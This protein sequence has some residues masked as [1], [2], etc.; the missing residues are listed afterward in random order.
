MAEVGASVA[1]GATTYA[2]AHGDREVSYLVH[3]TRNTA[4]LKI[5]AQELAA[6]REDIQKLID[7]SLNNNEVIKKSVTN[8][9]EKVDT[10][11]EDAS[12]LS[13]E[14]TKINRWYKG[15]LYSRFKLGRKAVKKIVVIQELL[16]E[17]SGFVSVGDSKPFQSFEIVSAGNFEA[18]ASREDATKK[19]VDA[20]QNNDVNMIGVFGMPGVGKTVLMKAITKQA[21]DE[22]IFDE[23]VIVSVSQKPDIRAIQKDIAEQLGLDLGESSIPVAA[24]KLSERLSQGKK[25]LVAF[26]DIWKELDMTILGIPYQS[27]IHSCKV[28]FTTRSEDV[29][30]RMEVHKKIEVRVLSEE[31]SWKLFRQKA[32]DVV[33]SSSHQE[34]ARDVFNECKGLPLAIVTL[35]LAL[36]NKDKTLWLD[37]STRLKKSMYKGMGPA[38]AIVKL[39]YDFL[40]D[41]KAAQMCFLFCSLFPEDFFINTDVLLSYML[42]EELMEKGDSMEEARN[43]LHAMIDKLTSSGILLRSEGG[44]IMMHDIIR[45]AAIG[46]SSSEGFIVKSG[47]GLK[48]W[49]PL[50]GEMEKC[51]RLSLMCNDL[52]FC[53]PHQITASLLFTLSLFQNENLEEIPS[54]FFKEM[55]HLKTLDLSETGIISLPPSFQCLESLHT[56]YMNRCLRLID[57]SLVGELH[58][59]VI[60]SIRAS[61]KVGIPVSMQKLTN[62][63]MLNAS[64]VRCLFPPK[65]ISSMH[66][67]EELYLYDRD[68]K[69]EV[70][71]SEVASL[72]RLTSLQIRLPVE[73]M[74]KDFPSHWKNLSNFSISVGEIDMDRF[75]Q[76]R[77]MSLELRSCFQRCQWIG[78]FRSILISNWVGVLSEKIERLELQD[79]HHLLTVAD[80]NVNGLYQNLSQLSV[81]KCARLRHLLSTTSLR[82]KLFSNLQ[83]LHFWNLEK[84]VAICEGPIPE[85]FLFKLKMLTVWMCSTVSILIPFD[86]L[87][88]LQ[89]LEEIRVKFCDGLE[90]LV[91][92]EGS[93]SKQP[94]SLIFTCLRIIHISYCNKLK[95]VLPMKAARHLLQLEELDI[96]FCSDMEM[97]FEGDDGDNADKVTA[98]LPHLNMLV[99][100]GLPS[101]SSFGPPGLLFD[102]PALIDMRVLGCWNLKRLPLLGKQ[103]IPKLKN[104]R[105]KPGWLDGLEWEDESLKVHLKSHPGLAEYR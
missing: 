95:C 58:R 26:D 4:N 105:V 81:S 47:L 72:T 44:D 9:L 73:C 33:D 88:S 52:S 48:E 92:L 104:L 8:W 28:L 60:L 101:L 1:G 31:D 36:R 99:L 51:K 25:V 77:S 46:I 102:F 49:P 94:P 65:V 45:D 74:L 98:T 5:K 32:G 68:I 14:A 50:D 75:S 63:K 41:D 64:G 12:K 55:K 70:V 96:S 89:K 29:C 67:L 82:L 10:V 21:K 56:L 53:P 76:T 17:R 103:S 80:L 93:I 7:A 38:I 62:L 90:N 40:D 97:V 42:G 37:A 6:T 78:H 34:V 3:F 24:T 19:V 20:L 30:D 39:S 15:W 66:R 79:C 57:I 100:W 91:Q 54:D 22:K 84:F 23:V 43:G 85:G 18:F 87:G 27:S 69:T 11:V 2:I 16:A 83:V 71:F 13:I 35:G 86:L 59:L 61:K